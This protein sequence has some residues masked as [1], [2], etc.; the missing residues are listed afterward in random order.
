MAYKEFK[1]G[2]HAKYY[3]ISKEKIR[4]HYVVTPYRS[5]P[6]NTKGYITVS[7]S[8]HHYKINK[9]GYSTTKKLPTRTLKPKRKRSSN[10]YSLFG[11]SKGFNW[12]W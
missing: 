4:G 8:K 9:N 12:R 2:E 1:T 7:G 11:S 10:N 5:K 6:T 3:T